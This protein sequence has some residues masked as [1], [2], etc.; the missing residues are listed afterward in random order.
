[1]R[2]KKRPHTAALTKQEIAIVR[3][4]AFPEW[5]NIRENTLEKVESVVARILAQGNDKER[6]APMRQEFLSLLTVLQHTTLKVVEFYADHHEEFERKLHDASRMDRHDEAWQATMRKWKEW[7][8]YMEGIPTSLNWLEENPFRLWSGIHFAMNPLMACYDLYNELATMMNEGLHEVIRSTNC[9]LFTIRSSIH[10]SNPA[11]VDD[12]AQQI[13]RLHQISA[14]I[15]DLAPVYTPDVI[16]AMAKELRYEEAFHNRLVRASLILRD[17]HESNKAHMQSMKTQLDTQRQQQELENM[18]SPNMAHYN[19]LSFLVYGNPKLQELEQKSQIIRSKT[20]VFN[21][22]HYFHLWQRCKFCEISVRYMLKRRKLRIFHWVM[23]GLYASKVQKHRLEAL[24]ERVLRSQLHVL[25]DRWKANLHWWKRFDAIY[26]RCNRD[27]MQFAIDRWQQ[28]LEEKQQW[29][30]ECL[31]PVLEPEYIRE[32]TKDVTSMLERGHELERNSSSSSMPFSVLKWI[33]NKA[34]QQL[35]SS[36]K[37]PPP[38][39]LPSSPFALASSM[40]P[41]SP[42]RRPHHIAEDD[43]LFPVDE[44][45]M[46][47]AAEDRLAM[48]KV[49]VVD[50]QSRATLDSE[51]RRKLR[52]AEAHVTEKVARTQLMQQRAFRAWRKAY[53]Q[54]RLV[55]RMC[56]IMKDYQVW[57][58]WRQWR[59]AMKELRFESKIEKRRQELLREVYDGQ[60]PP[61]EARPSQRSWV[62]SRS[63]SMTM[64]EGDV[65]SVSSSNQGSLL[66]RSSP[67]GIIPE[68]ELRYDGDFSNTFL[69]VVSPTRATMVSPALPMH[70]VRH[71][72]VA[73]SLKDV[74]IIYRRK[75]RVS[76]EEAENEER[77]ARS[78][79]GVDDE[80]A[81]SANTAGDGVGD[82]AETT[83]TDVG[84]GGSRENVGKVEKV[85]ESTDESTLATVDG[86]VAVEHATIGAAS[87]NEPADLTINEHTAT[88]NVVEAKSTS[89]SVDNSPEESVSYR[90]DEPI[91]AAVDESVCSNSPE[92]FDN[93]NGIPE[94]GDAAKQLAAHKLRQRDQDKASSSIEN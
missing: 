39:E 29:R 23:S 58:A 61:L 13:L 76:N 87:K 57:A 52:A 70:P 74:P 28:F 81:A 1:M 15:S 49:D 73:F 59:A 83:A 44:E 9:N 31:L 88:P 85:T 2:K 50:E 43:L 47:P 6:V 62:M 20:Q 90:Q 68:T 79:D 19:R 27:R 14:P 75:L 21:T 7:K 93:P 60:P 67:P 46:S 94:S 82:S 16:R 30:V 26:F 80:H 37:P 84:G 64:D 66:K 91:A 3:D 71:S 41:S 77:S 48:G 42:Q 51:T 12:L 4:V 36:N 53:N 72:Q 38:S 63:M 33:R 25:L 24:R 54:Q 69:P 35:S 86:E 17:V 65:D 32:T 56:F 55:H 40:P 5:I 10:I 89:P 45:A 22:R 8:A 11:L 34:F 78:P 18:V 92:N